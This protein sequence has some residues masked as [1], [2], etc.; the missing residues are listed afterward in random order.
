MMDKKHCKGC[1]NNFYNSS[2]GLNGECWSLKSAKVEWR[3]PVGNWERPPYN[4]KKVRVASCYHE[5]GSNKTH[6]IKPE[7]LDSS[8]YW[9]H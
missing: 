7:A 5:S 4:K 9:K 2:N 1:R 8:G 6:Y 3:I